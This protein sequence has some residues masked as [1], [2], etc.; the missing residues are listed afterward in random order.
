M[1]T[2]S[3][4]LL[5]ALSQAQDSDLR[6]DDMIAYQLTKTPSGARADRVQMQGESS[7][8]A[9]AANGAAGRLTA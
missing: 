9:A 4:T 2:H 3:E 5:S 7:A 1:T 8:Q 6:Q